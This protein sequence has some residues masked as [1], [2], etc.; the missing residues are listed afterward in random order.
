MPSVIPIDLTKNPDVAALVADKEPGSEVYGCFTIKSRDDQ[1][2]ELRIK[3][4]AATC[5]ELK[6]LEDDDEDEETGQSPE[7]D[8]AEAPEP[9]EPRAKKFARQFESNAQ[10]GY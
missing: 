10:D 4:M 7:G 5:D 6:D 3:G 1:T 2:L 8:E 9:P